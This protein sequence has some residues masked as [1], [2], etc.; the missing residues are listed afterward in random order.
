MGNSNYFPSFTVWVHAAV[1]DPNEGFGQQLY[2]GQTHC[3]KKDVEIGSIPLKETTK[4]T[5]K[6]KH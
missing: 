6:S 4:K 3:G 5:P 2:L 1:R